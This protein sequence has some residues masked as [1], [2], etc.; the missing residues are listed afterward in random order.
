MLAR[1]KHIKPEVFFVC[2]SVFF[3]VLFNIATPPLQAPDEFNHFYRAYQLAEGQFLPNKIDN[4][5]GGEIPNCINEFVFP[6]D[7]AATE[8]SLTLTPKDVFNGFKIKYTK[9]SVQF[10]DFPHPSYYSLVSYLPQVI[11]IYVTKKLHCSIGT[12]YYAGRLLSFLVWLCC[13]CFVIKITPVYKWLF[14]A[15]CLL[16]MNIYITNSFSADTS[17]NVL[18]FLF[19]ALALKHAFLKGNFTLKNLLPFLII[20]ALI[21][22]A[23]VVY[24]ALIFSFLIIPINKF[25][26]K[27][28]YFLLVG[29]LFLVAFVA[30][31]Y[32]SGIVMKYYTP[33]SNYNTA[34][35]DWICLTHNSNYYE[36]KAYILSHGTY[37][38]KVI[39][40]SIFDHPFT[41]L[42]GYIGL[43]GNSDIFLPKWVLVFSYII[44]F[45]IA[46]FENNA[47]K[48]T[49][50]QKTILLGASFCSFVLL[51]LSQHLTWDA[52]GEGVVDLIQ[53]RY[54]IPLFPFLLFI[55]SNYRLKINIRYDILLSIFFCVLYSISAYKIID[56]YY[57]GSRIQKEVIT[58]DAE[59]VNTKGMFLT[60]NTNILLQ[61]GDSKTDSI[62][63]NGKSSLLLSERSPF[64]FTYKF[65]NLSSG[66]LLEI[67][68]WQ[69][70]QG[71]A[72]VISNDN[73]NKL[74]LP[75]SN[76]YYYD[77]KGWG[78]LYIKYLVSEKCENNTFSF[79]VWNP[80]KSKAYIDDLVFSIKRFSK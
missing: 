66:D 76:V 71:A 43:F 19:I 79:Y 16:P 36:Q 4:R 45:F 63:H 39:Y 77:N 54:L 51:L 80:T 74:Y 11:A 12:M 38:L 47:F 56:R 42:Q 53:G 13:M 75:S 9:D 29:V 44:I 58:C 5:L 2:A 46:L 15:I 41:Y 59:S 35:R 28:Q 14:T 49:L 18:S 30:A 7:N 57:K 34:Y 65:N 23:K 24:A 21:A 48:F 17:S 55:L 20:A 62:A 67:S 6:F 72:L 70:G 22:L 73:C 52:V 10:K 40:R 26:T 69:K 64:G 8:L 68:L 25:K 3:F 1:I 33:Y 37:F 31:S 50:L 32:W 78:R 60:S 61:G 27:G